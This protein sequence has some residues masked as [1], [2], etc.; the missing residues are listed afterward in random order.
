MA[1]NW[2]V[3]S[4][5]VFSE[6]E[7]HPKGTIP[8][9]V[10]QDKL[11]LTLIWFLKIKYLLRQSHK[12]TVCTCISHNLATTWYKCT[13]QMKFFYSEHCVCY[14]ACTHAQQGYYA[15]YV[16]LCWYNYVA[17]NWLFGAIIPLKNLLSVFYIIILLCNLW[18]PIILLGQV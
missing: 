2:D 14:P 11:W 8:V 4:S 3:W 17:K 13:M 6:W 18:V 1:R 5:A 7:Q 9:H 12:E 15:L 10:H 16:Y